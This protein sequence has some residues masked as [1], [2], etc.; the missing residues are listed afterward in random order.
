MADTGAIGKD[1]IIL[2]QGLAPAGSARYAPALG[3]SPPA[4]AAR[5]GLS[6]NPAAME[7]EPSAAEVP[8]F[9][10]KDCTLIA[11]A[12]GLKAWTLG[13]LMSGIQRAP[14]DSLYYHFWGTLL[15]ASFE[16][17]EYNNEFAAW[18]RYALHEHALAERLA[19]ID[20][21]GYDELEAMRD[22]L[23]EI[24]DA[25]LQAAEHLA[26]LRSTEPFEFLR[27]Q[28]VVF[29]TERRVAHPDAMAELVPTLSASSIF[30]HFIDARRRNSNH[31]DDFRAWLDGVPGD[32]AD[33]CGRLAGIDPWFGQLTELRGAIAAA[34]AGND[35][36]LQ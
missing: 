11:I 26:W 1:T 14:A 24:L 18:V 30:Y 12:T 23:L 19:A 13:E 7:R 25:G 31:R 34:F 9:A 22:E 6:R 32:H 10:V 27:H 16:E 21:T 17:R 2:T 36:T 4:A 28:I 33:A 29:D 35:D 8:A 3:P 5:A 15:Q 20:P